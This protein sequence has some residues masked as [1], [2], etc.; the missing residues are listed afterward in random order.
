MGF[1][2]LIVHIIENFEA[3]QQVSQ[4]DG[5]LDDASLR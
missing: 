3:R 5:G 1:Y 2:G 4:A